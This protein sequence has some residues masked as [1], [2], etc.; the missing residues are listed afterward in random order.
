[1][2][3][4]PTAIVG[5][6]AAAVLL[7]IAWQARRPHA[8]ESGKSLFERRCGGCHAADRDMEGPRLRGVY[9]RAAA[10]SKSFAY[11]DALR[12]SGIVWSAEKLE[13]WLASPEALVPGT[14]ME[15]HLESASER[16]AIIQY[17]K[18]LSRK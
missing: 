11:S 10:S 5:R 13:G 15:F 18:Q 2:R 4:R 16:Q 9:G 1:M 3:Q 8:E 12:R 14:E 7:L 17:L 6:A